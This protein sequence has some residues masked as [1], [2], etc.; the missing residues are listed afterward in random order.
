MWVEQGNER[1]E[2]VVGM[3][4]IRSQMKGGKGNQDNEEL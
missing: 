2:I 3:G 4:D 1:E